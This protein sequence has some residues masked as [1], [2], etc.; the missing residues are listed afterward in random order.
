MGNNFVTFTD[1]KKT[2]KLFVR[3]NHYQPHGSQMLM[4]QIVQNRCYLLSGLSAEFKKG[5]K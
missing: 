1:G 5:T 4:G 3:H 2:M